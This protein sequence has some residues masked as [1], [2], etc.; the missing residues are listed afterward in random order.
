LPVENCVVNFNQKFELFKHLY[1]FGSRLGV[2]QLRLI[3][4]L[5]N[6][7]IAAVQQL[8]DGICSVPIAGEQ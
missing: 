6:N 5:T 2:K 7:Q 1:S 8:L 3:I 4:R